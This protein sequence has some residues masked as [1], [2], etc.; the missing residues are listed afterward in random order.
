L[1]ALLAFVIF[2]SWRQKRKYGSS[3]RGHA[4]GLMRA[5]M[6]EVQQL[7]EPEKKV[8]VIRQPEDGEALL[9]RFKKPDSQ[10]DPGSE[11]DV[12]SNSSTD[13]AT[14]ARG[15]ADGKGWLPRPDRSG[16]LKRSS[17]R[18][19]Q[20]GDTPRASGSKR[21]AGGGWQSKSPRASRKPRGY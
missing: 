12:A 19:G 5:G 9:V 2:E 20:K 21:G 8:E 4:A 14:A 6:L 18:K 7:L 15:R 16:G 1:I 10:G 11:D 13:A 17:R 3:G